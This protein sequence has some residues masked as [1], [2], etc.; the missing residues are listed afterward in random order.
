MRILSALKFILCGLASV[1]L[2]TPLYAAW[3]TITHENSNIEIYIPTQVAETMSNGTRNEY[4]LMVNLHG[5]AQSSSILKANGNWE[6]AAEE[7]NTIVALPSVPEGGV[8]ASCWDYYGIDHKRDNRHNGFLLSLV[9][10]LTTTYPVEKESIFLSGLSSGGGES[11]VMAC[12]APDIFAGIGLNAGPALGS[13]AFQTTRASLSVDQVVANCR[14]LA[15]TG[16]D[17]L[18]KLVVS[19]IHGDNDYIVDTN[20]NKLNADVFA[21]ILETDSLQPIDMETLP[22]T[23]LKGKG[24]LYLKNGKPLVSLIENKGIGHAWPAGQG[25]TSGDFVAKDSVNYPK[26]LLEFLITNNQ[27]L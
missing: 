2:S 6:E 17:H 25:G 19:I 4:P 7:F 26:Y 23:N 13:T 12:L 1:S 3:Q 24:S 18:S 27:R 10:K 20:Y 15:G 8:Y 11:L 22:G 21:K 9:K 16:K 5:C 14:N